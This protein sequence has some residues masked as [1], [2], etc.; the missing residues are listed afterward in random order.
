MIENGAGGTR[1]LWELP[2]FLHDLHTH[3]NCTTVDIFPLV[4]PTAVMDICDADH[5]E[6]VSKL[7]H[8]KFDLIVLESL[9]QPCFLNSQKLGNMVIN[10]LFLLSDIGKIYIPFASPKDAETTQEVFAMFA[11]RLIQN[12]SQSSFMYP[13]IRR[14]AGDKYVDEYLMKNKLECDELNKPPENKDFRFLL[15]AR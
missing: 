6:I 9:P 2:K 7:G 12:S 5:G 3:P 10:C 11:F 13:T 8:E 4:E 15:F 14:L 1:P